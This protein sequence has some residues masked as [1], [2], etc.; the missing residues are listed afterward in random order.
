[1]VEHLSLL[2]ACSQDAS[3]LEV[4]TSTR[5]LQQPCIKWMAVPD[6]LKA[7]TSDESTHDE[8][9]SRRVEAGAPVYVRSRG[10]SLKLRNVWS[11]S[12]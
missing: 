8:I 1:M 3:V 5:R 4:L 7:Y 12:C 10:G 2:A 11:C 9:R 6:T